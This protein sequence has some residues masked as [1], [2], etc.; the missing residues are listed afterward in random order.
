MNP[1]PI[2]PGFITAHHRHRG[3]EAEPRAAL[4]Q[5]PIDATP[6]PAH[7]APQ[8][9]R[10]AEPRHHRQLPLLFPQLKRHIQ[11]RLAYTHLR[12]GC[13]DHHSLLFGVN[14]LKGAYSRGPL[15]VSPWLV[16][17]KPRRDYEVLYLV[18]HFINTV[19]YFNLSIG[20]RS[21]YPHREEV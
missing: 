15:I 21:G 7:Y 11:R 16:Q 6:I 3:R 20:G 4:R 5:R 17:I 8:P 10:D 1:E 18:L 9:R 13:C 12:A 2:A 14:I 19:T